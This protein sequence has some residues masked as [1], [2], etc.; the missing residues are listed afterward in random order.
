MVNLQ[1]I[2]ATEAR[3][4]FFSLLKKSYFKKQN[5]LIEKGG[6]PMVYMVSVNGGLSQKQAKTSKTKKNL[7]LLAAMEKFQKN[8]KKTSDS[9]LLLR[10]MRR[11]GR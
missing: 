8:M 11:Y 5:F 9:V 10:K 7:R 2:K 4:N 3:N 6:I 1:I